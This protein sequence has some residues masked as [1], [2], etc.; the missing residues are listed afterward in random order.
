M[1]AEAATND[2]AKARLVANQQEISN[3]STIGELTASRN[4]KSIDF[5]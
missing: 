5:Q 3:V 1:D 2:F 4:T